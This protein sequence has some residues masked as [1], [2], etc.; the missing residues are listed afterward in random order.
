MM[1]LSAC[2][3]ALGACE[4]A[5]R[6]RGFR[7]YVK[8]TGRLEGCGL[9]RTLG[10]PR[11]GKR[12]DYELRFNDCSR[13]HLVVFNDGHAEVHIDRVSPTC[14]PLGHVLVD[15][16][17]PLAWVQ[18]LLGMTGFVLGS[19]WL[20]ITGLAGIGLTLIARLLLN[21]ALR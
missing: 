17:K 18:G 4:L 15:A 6:L 13:C 2:R 11:R 19:A 5:W 14:S 16:W 3:R 10:S 7:I 8:G 1:V 21:L 9:Q 12:G 20:T